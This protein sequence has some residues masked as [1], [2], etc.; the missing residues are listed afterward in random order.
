MD[1]VIQKQLERLPRL[2]DHLFSQTLLQK[3]P[4]TIGEHYRDWLLRR[5]PVSRDKCIRGIFDCG[6]S[7]DKP[8]DAAPLLLFSVLS[9]KCEALLA[10]ENLKDCDDPAVSFIVHVLQYG[11][12]GFAQNIR[13]VCVDDLQC[14]PAVI[15]LTNHPRSPFVEW[16]LAKHGL[17]EKNETAAMSPDRQRISKFLGS[18]SDIIDLLRVFDNATRCL[19]PWDP[20]VF[21]IL[22]SMAAWHGG[23]GQHVQQL[24]RL[25]QALSVTHRRHMAFGDP[26]N[27]HVLIQIIKATTYQMLDGKA[28]H[29]DVLDLGKRLALYTGG[30]PVVHL[31]MA[32]TLALQSNAASAVFHLGMYRRSARDAIDE[33]EQ[34]LLNRV[35]DVLCEK[36]IHTGFTTSQQQDHGQQE[37]HDADASAEDSQ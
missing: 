5:H 31:C 24:A 9:G 3:S 13:R 11:A 18:A 17:S 27:V 25:R 21:E 16:F 15:W 34:R 7:S 29:D 1:E 36:G 14:C 26:L 10:I 30:F 28:S 23:R 6:L 4:R 33:T 20:E 32:L 12:D 2:H 22:M 19:R 35:T 8:R 37:R